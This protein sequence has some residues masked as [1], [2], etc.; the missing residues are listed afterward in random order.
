MNAIDTRFAELKKT[1]RKALI[2]Y[3]TAGLPT[4]AGF[5]GV[6]AAMQKAGVDLLEIGVPF[7]DPVADGPTIQRASQKA[8]K[9]GVTLDWILRTV[10]ALKGIRMPIVLMTYA[11][12]IMS[13]GLNAFF[14]R[15][16]QSGVSGV[17]VPDLI[18]EE[19]KPFEQAAEQN[20]IALIYL[21]A[22]T[23]SPDR[24]RRIAR[25]TRG[26]LYA[27]SLTGITGARRALS[28]GVPAFVARLRKVTSKPIALG[29]GI[30]TPDQVRAVRRHV[31]GVIVG[32]ALVDQLDASV[33]KAQ[34][35]VASLQ[36]ALNP[37]GA[38]HAS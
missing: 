8:L 34:S 29:F 16:R 3:V 24:I 25:A 7:S 9:N 14:A 37:K 1:G 21:A 35:F 18:P 5:P 36:K 31:D 12:P 28:S 13:A 33:S 11:N 15:A 10:K 20:G 30:S 26:F 2:G 22:P 38:N 32:S 23:T 6:V 27:V 4:K 17:I 19:G